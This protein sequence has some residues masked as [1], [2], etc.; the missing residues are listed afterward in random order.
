MSDAET[1]EQVAN[2]SQRQNFSSWRT[3]MMSIL[4]IGSVAFTWA[5]STQFSKTALV[6]DP[7]TQRCARATQKSIT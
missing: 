5:M 6:I 1:K 2:A 7:C 4:V 3:V